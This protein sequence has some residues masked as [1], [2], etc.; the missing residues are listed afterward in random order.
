MKKGICLLLTVVLVFSMTVSV[1]AVNYTKIDT[2]EGL[3]IAYMHTE[4]LSAEMRQEVLRAREEIIF[5]TSWVVE[6]ARGEILDENGNVIETVP[7][8]YELFPADW[9]IPTV[10]VSAETTAVIQSDSYTGLLYQDYIELSRPSS[11]HNTAPFYTATM[12]GFV[13]TAYEY[14]IE[15]IQVNGMYGNP[16]NTGTFNL[17]YSNADT[18][19]SLGYF[20]YL[21]ALQV[22]AAFN[23]PSGTNRVGI[24][25][26]TYDSVGTWYMTVSATRTDVV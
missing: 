23:P 2:E 15:D 3:S 18:G 25:A 19:I 13:D 10:P 7:E 16:Q 5:S 22:T 26:S 6:G 12:R 8:F 1:G 4:N 17:G 9:D 14:Y 11:S 24:R 21:P 20:T